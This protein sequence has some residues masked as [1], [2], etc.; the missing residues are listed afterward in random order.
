MEG[1]SLKRRIDE[2][3]ELKTKPDE[4]DDRSRERRR[5]PQPKSSS[6]KRSG[7]LSR[8]SLARLRWSGERST[9]RDSASVDA[10]DVSLERAYVDDYM[11]EY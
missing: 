6:K 5:E 3:V 8:E 2:G 11:P 9:R 1:S 4:G 10:N 7:R